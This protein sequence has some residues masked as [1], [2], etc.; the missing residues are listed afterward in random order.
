MSW[1]LYQLCWSLYE[2][3][4]TQTRIVNPAWQRHK[5]AVACACDCVR[6]RARYDWSRAYPD[7]SLAWQACQATYPSGLSSSWA[8]WVRDPLWVAAVGASP[9]FQ[10]R[11]S[12]I[13]CICVY[14]CVS[15]WCVCPAGR[16]IM[17]NVP[18]GSFHRRGCGW[19]WCQVAESRR[20]NQSWRPKR[21]RRARWCHQSQ[22]YLL[23]NAHKCAMLLVWNRYSGMRS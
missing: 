1:F 2:D 22:W 20:I 17:V 8:F 10:H 5:H 12:E 3:A 4:D 23:W 14:V 9:A 18:T 21:G 19:C 15:V 7:R 11:P 6:T 16:P 13:V